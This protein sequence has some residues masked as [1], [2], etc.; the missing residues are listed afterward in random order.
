MT[1]LSKSNYLKGLQCPKLL[2]TSIHDKDQLPEITKQDQKKFDEGSQ[3]GQLAKQLFPDGIDIPEDD[4]KENLEKSKELI[5]Q[6]KCLFEVAIRKDDLYSRADILDP[7]GKDQWDII[8][9]KSGTKVK[10]VNIEDVAFQKYVYEKSGLKI[11][12]CFLLHLNNEYIR[13]GEINI[14]ELFTKEDITEEVNKIKDIEKRVAKM[15]DTINSPNCPNIDIHI[16]CNDPYPCPLE[17]DCW[18]FL[19]NNSIFELYR[20]HKKKCFHLISEGVYEMK[21]IPSNFKLNDKQKIQC[22]CAE[23]GEPHIDKVEIK[24]F[25]DDLKYPLYY[26]DFETY[27]TAVPLYDGLKPYSQVPFQFSLHIQKEPSG[28]TEHFEFLGS[29]GDCRLEFITKLKEFLGTKGHIVVYNQS[30]EKARLKELAEFFPEFKEWVDSINKRII[31][32]LIPFRDFCY[33]HPNQKGSCSIKKVLPSITGKGYDGMEIDNG[34]LAS[35]EYFDMIF[36]NREDKDKIRK[37]LL[38]YCKL[39][40]E[41]MVWIINTLRE[42]VNK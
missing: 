12:K 18:G 5:K 36:G 26:L 15:L 11:R 35:F 17:K 29:K 39:D 8:E 9:V 14:Q 25:L 19:P 31:D 38:K 1:L 20:L 30:F 40:T 27:S 37:N 2:W 32:L 33:Y 13:K 4:F 42:K 23:T 34:G 7:V 16:K 24:K 21:D 10:P 22:K 41:G 28:E 6:R 3:V